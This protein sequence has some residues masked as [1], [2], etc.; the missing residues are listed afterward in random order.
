MLFASWTAHSGYQQPSHVNGCCSQQLFWWGL[1]ASFC[2]FSGQSQ[3]TCFSLTSRKRAPAALSQEWMLP[4]WAE[5]RLL[6][7]PCSSRSLLLQ[8]VGPGVSSFSGAALLVRGRFSRWSQ[9]TCVFPDLSEHECHH[10]GSPSGTGWALLAWDPS[11]RNAEFV[12]FLPL[13]GV[14]SPKGGNVPSC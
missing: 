4:L 10:T 9:S 13:Q 3:G 8:E 2:R 5:L 14:C 6:C 1:L 12:L 7:F 11:D